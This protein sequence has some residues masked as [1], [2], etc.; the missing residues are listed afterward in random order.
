MHRL[1][2]QVMIDAEDRLLVEGAEQRAVQGLRRGQ[3]I[4]ERLLHDH[5]G[6]LRGARPGQLLHHGAEERRGNGQVMRGPLGRAQLLA[7]RLEGGRVAV[8]AVDV[9]QEAAQLVGR[10]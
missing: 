4:A 3:V 2:P 7:E 9:A 1:L 10:R 5:T 6:A 8:V